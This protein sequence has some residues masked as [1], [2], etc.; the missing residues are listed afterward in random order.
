MSAEATC[1]AC[2]AET[3][4]YVCLFCGAPLAVATDATSE[5]Q[6]LEELHQAI[7]HAT[8]DEQRA[9]ILAN[10]AIPDDDRVL[11]DAGLRTAAL[12]DPE[13]YVDQMPG[14]AIARIESIRAKLRMR[15]NAAADRELGARVAEYQR[16]AA[17]ESSTGFKIVLVIGVLLALMVVAI[18]FVVKMK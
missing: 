15:S 2:G 14:A 7:V 12:L 18:V 16:G 10:G 1:R 9:R 17:R 8:E 5:R 11:V 13:R 4:G 6:A 3:S